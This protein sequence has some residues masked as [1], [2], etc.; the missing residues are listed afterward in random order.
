MAKFDLTFSLGGQKIAATA[1]SEG[2]LNG[3]IEYA[4]DLFDRETVQAIAAR[5]VRLLEAVAAA[6]DRP[7]ARIDLLDS[8]ERQRILVEWN[9]TEHALPRAGLPQLFEAQLA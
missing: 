1:G 2:S 9:A 4:S 6:P 3:D 5:F 7:V 8:A